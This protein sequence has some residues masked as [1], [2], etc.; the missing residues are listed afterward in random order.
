[1]PYYPGFMSRPALAS[2]TGSPCPPHRTVAG[3]GGK[4]ACRL[5]LCAALLVLGCG[6]NATPPSLP[7]RVRADGVSY[8]QVWQLASHNSYWA[9]RRGGDP[10]VSGVS[11]RLLDQLL[12]D[13]VRT[14]ELDIHPAET[15][16]EFRVYH[17][18]PGDS[19]CDSLRECLAVLRLFQHTLPQH[20]P[21]LV[22]LELKHLFAPM[23]DAEHSPEDLDR[24]LREEL[25]STLYAPGDF[26]QPCLPHGITSLRECMQQSGWPAVNDLAG[27][28]LFATMGYWHMFGGSNDVAWVEYSTSR[29]MAERAAFPLAINTRY[30]TLNSDGQAAISESAFEQAMAQAMFWYSEDEN[31]PLTLEFV[32]RG[33][34]VMYGVATAPD[35]QLRGIAKGLQILQTDTPWVAPDPDGRDQPLR[36]LD[37]RRT[38]QPIGELD[39]AL[40]IAAGPDKAAEVALL[41]L[42]PA[43]Q[44]SDWQ[45]ILISGHEPQLAACL[46]AASQPDSTAT[47]V[48]LCR[49]LVPNS[50]GPNSLRLRLRLQICQDGR[51]SEDDYLSGDTSEGGAGE[52]VA[53]RIT[54]RGSQTCIAARS[55]R[56][57]SRPTEDGPG[58]P[59]WTALGDERCLPAKLPYQGIVRRP[60]SS[61][62]MPAAQ[63]AVSFFQLTRNGQTLT[64][65]DLTSDVP[66]TAAARR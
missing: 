6:G 12:A 49:Q 53:L 13:G 20:R 50:S 42:V 32:Q 28:V 45:A 15:P 57:V 3:L 39:S 46:R 52:R 16:H 34:V 54:P 29:P 41:A 18:Q 10:W 63:A 47:S 66:R 43:E 35:R 19:Q 59:R 25:G 14:I 37:S 51:C 8:S 2:Q 60:L 30:Y 27:R 33:G 38:P 40:R 23:W 65:A 21:L 4:H 22:L 48:T 5:L 1:M 55:A 58:T 24:I 62:G 7:P 64:L 9:E 17:L 11:E 56:V 61:P 26:L 36:L 31:D 44:A